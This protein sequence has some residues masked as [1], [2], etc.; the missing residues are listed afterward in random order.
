M[1]SVNQI[2]QRGVNV[3]HCPNMVAALLTKHKTT[4]N[5]RLSILCKR[6]AWLTSMILLRTTCISSSGRCQ[7]HRSNGHS[8]PLL[9]A[10]LQHFVLTNQLHA[11]SSVNDPTAMLGPT[12]DNALAWCRVHNSVMAVNNA[13]STHKCTHFSLTEREGIQKRFLCCSQVGPCRFIATLRHKNESPTVTSGV[14]SPVLKEKKRSRRYSHGRRPR[15]R[16]RRPCGIK[17]NVS[18]ETS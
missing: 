6:S 14:A 2:A 9:E 1:Q 10:W 17:T 12:S 16:T 7:I 18:T 5:P 11:L 3:D 13:P 4:G 8:G 15:R